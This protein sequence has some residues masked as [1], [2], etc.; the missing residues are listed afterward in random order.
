VWSDECMPTGVVWFVKAVEG[1][2]WKLLQCITAG[3]CMLNPGN[4]A[5]CGRPHLRLFSQ[6]TVLGSGLAADALVGRG[7]LDC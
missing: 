2:S 4:T 3:K 1:R 7:N 5:L 6:G